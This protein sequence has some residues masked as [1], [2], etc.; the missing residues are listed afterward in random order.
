MVGRAAKDASLVQSPLAAIDIGSTSVHLL[1]ASVADHAVRPIADE[2]ILLGLGPHVDEHGLI[3]G[4]AR[5]DLLVALAHYVDLARTCG[6]ADV[7]IVATE[8]LRRARDAAAVVVDA[9]IRVGYDVE[10]LT[11]EEEALLTLLGVTQGLPVDQELAVIDIGGG[12]S[13]IVFVDRNRTPRTAGVALGAA[14]LT[15][16]YASED[17]P[18]HRDLAAMRRAAVELLRGVP[19]EVPRELVAVGGTATNVLRVVPEADD[20]VLDHLRL[21]SALEALLAAP[22][23]VVAEEWGIRPERARILPAGVVILEAVLDRLGLDQLAVSDAGI[24]EGALLALGHDGRAWRRRL[25]RTV[26]GWR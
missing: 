14:R 1:V 8:P 19:H 26:H 13:E 23:R 3:A 5:E 4:T 17:P 10:V 18:S 6:C 12:S 16:R 2:S 15:A 22:A 24:R 25:A 11:H 9:A 21:G 20:R 7:S